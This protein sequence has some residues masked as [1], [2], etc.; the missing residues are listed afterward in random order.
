M[1]KNRTITHQL[2]LLIAGTISTILCCTII[3]FSIERINTFLEDQTRQTQAM[4]SVLGKTVQAAVVFKDRKEARRILSALEADITVLEAALF[5]REGEQLAEYVIPGQSF[6]LTFSAPDLKKNSLALGF[7]TV[8]E[9]I[10]LAGKPIGTIIIRTSLKPLYRS[11]FNFLMTMLI[12]LAITIMMAARLS[13]RLSELIA[14]PIALLAKGMQRIT[15]EG[16]YSITVSHAGTREIKELIEGFNTMIAQINERDRELARTVSKLRIAKEKADSSNRAKSRFLANMSHEIRTPLNGVL[17]MAE[18]LQR[19]SLSPDQE[20]YTRSILDSGKVLLAVINDIL[21]SSRIEA[22]KMAI[23]HS[24]FDI[25]GTVREVVNVFQVEANQK[26]VALKTGIAEN[27]PMLLGDSD[28]IRQI[29]FNL[30]GNALKFTSQGTVRISL[31][32]RAV[33]SSRTEVRVEISDTGIGISKD[34]LK[35]IFSPFSQGDGSTTRIYGGSGLG[36]SIVHQ[37]VT[38][39]KGR[40]KVDSTLGRGSTFHVTIPFEPAPADAVPADSLS[41]V[42]PAGSA[43]NSPSILLVEDNPANQ[44]L[45]KEALEAIGCRVEVAANGEQA[46]QAV[47][48]NSFD[49][50]FMDCQMPVMD[51]YTAASRIRE[52]EKKSGRNRIPVIAVTAHV[53]ADNKEQCLQSG[54]DDYLQKPFSLNGLQA[55]LERWVGARE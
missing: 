31:T 7:I 22:G 48:R 11:I 34:Q 47:S 10:M 42:I 6:S 25:A 1:F 13:S 18:L 29:L 27:V 24:P 8:R 33:D 12:I 5:T 26:G 53:L 49:I 15:R 36:L 55:C 4:C 44:E 19:T 43:P 28:R 39:M 52:M 2:P 46:V 9:P 14:L 51:G 38:L 30:I 37:L 45:A 41:P 16:N 21:D 3:F 20:R 23:G 40:I 50:V 17:G 54:M 35:T 32:H